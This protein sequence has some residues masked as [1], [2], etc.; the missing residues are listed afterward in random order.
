MGHETQYRSITNLLFALVSGP[1]PLWTRLMGASGWPQAPQCL[2]SS[3]AGTPGHPGSAHSAAVPPAAGLPAELPAEFPLRRLIY[4]FHRKCSL[5]TSHHCSC[6]AAHLVTNFLFQGIWVAWL[7]KPL[8]RGLNSG[9]D[10]T[11]CGFEPH[12]GLCAESM[13]PAWGLASLS[14]CLSPSVSQKNT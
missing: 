12:S 5:P 6:S 14:H 7:V 9:H 2:P 4:L 8:T 11:V 1:S 13:E 10:L 3:W